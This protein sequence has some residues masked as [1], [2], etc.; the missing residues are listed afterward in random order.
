MLATAVDT[1][2]MLGDEASVACY[3][4]S[5][6]ID[7]PKP[8]GLE[9]HWTTPPPS[10][11]DSTAPSQVRY[12][13][14]VQENFWT[15]P[16]NQLLLG[17]DYSR[18]RRLCLNET[19]GCDS[20]GDCCIWHSNVHSCRAEA[21]SC[22]PWVAPQ[23]ASGS[24]GAAYTLVTHT[25]SLTGGLEEFTQNVQLEDGDWVIIAHVKIMTFQC[26]VGATRLSVTPPSVSDNT[27]TIVLAVVLPLAAVIA[28]VVIIGV[29]QQ[30]RSGEVRDISDAPKEGNVTLIFTDI[31]DSTNLWSKFTASMAASLD[32][33]HEVIRKAI[34]KHHGYEVKTAGDS[35]MIAVKTTEAAAKLVAQIQEDL[36]AEQWPRCITQHY[37]GEELEDLPEQL[38]SVEPGVAYHGVRVRIGMHTGTP[39]CMFDEVSKGYDYYGPDVN[40]S[41]RVEAAA[42]G[43]QI[44]LSADAERALS[45]NPV[46]GLTTALQGTILPKGLSEPHEVFTLV[47]ESIPQRDFPKLSYTNVT[48]MGGEDDTPKGDSASSHQ[49]VMVNATREEEML[50]ERLVE[51]FKFELTSEYIA[52]VVKDRQSFLT[53]LMKPLNKKKQQQLLEIISSGWRLPQGKSSMDTINKLMLRV[54]PAESAKL[55]ANYRVENG[56]SESLSGSMSMGQSYNMRHQL[57]SVPSLTSPASAAQQSSSAFEQATQPGA[58]RDG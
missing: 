19:G 46:P 24:G 41:A 27:A 55:R 13:A 12:W 57:H 5:S 1:P 7:I 18:Y 50:I 44:L 23:N 48:L 32:L 39:D 40:L 58:V 51:A 15:H 17:A 45:E 35:F 21:G 22:E 31:Q 10:P 28:A 9:M 30:K 14:R 56:L 47:V 11:L 20:T 3:S 26:A 52:R 43:G 16:S 33:H 42:T 37:L 25:A 6:Q 36:M 2:W 54:I 53:T 29:M 38:E 34:K 49:S 8:V 4:L